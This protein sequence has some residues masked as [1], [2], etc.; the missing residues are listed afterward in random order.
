MCVCVCVSVCVC[1]CV[2]LAGSDVPGSLKL[3][4]KHCEFIIFVYPE[5]DEWGRGDWARAL[6]LETSLMK[7]KP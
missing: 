1:V 6:H 4:Q 2:F 3:N 5:E 7:L